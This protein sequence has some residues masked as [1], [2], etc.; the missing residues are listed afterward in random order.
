LVSFNTVKSWPLAT[1]LPRLGCVRQPDRLCPPH[2][3]ALHNAHSSK[4][5]PLPRR[6]APVYGTDNGAM[7][8][9]GE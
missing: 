6:H 9:H 8:R 2:P 3:N 5:Y 4:S 7:R 1:Q